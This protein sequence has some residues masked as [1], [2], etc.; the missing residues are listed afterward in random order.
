MS[1]HACLPRAPCRSTG[2]L[3][4]CCGRN[5][6]LLLGTA[7]GRRHR[8]KLDLRLVHNLNREATQPVGGRNVPPSPPPSKR[9]R[10]RRHMCLHFRIE[11]FQCNT[12][13]F[14]GASRPLTPPS[15]LQAAGLADRDLL[16]VRYEGEQPHVLPYFLA[17]DENTRCLVLAIRGG[18]YAEAGEGEAGKAGEE[19]GSVNYVVVP[20][21]PA[22]PPA[23]LPA[24][25]PPCL[26]ALPASPL[27]TSTS[28]SV[29][30]CNCA[31]V[32]LCNSAVQA[33]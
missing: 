14:I 9:R 26:P 16:D 5:C 29:Q 7:Q 3:Q 10:R 25:L 15:P 31:T 4:V 30:L 19:A 27:Q 21:L 8:K 18:L 13:I 22:C 24:C 33:P 11:S 17:A 12:L 28:A 20:C 1:P 32:Q 23:C 2:C 6:G